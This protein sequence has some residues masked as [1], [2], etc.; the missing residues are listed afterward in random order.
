MA[1][2]EISVN[3]L[4]L[5]EVRAYVTEVN[6]QVERMRA[7][8]EAAVVIVKLLKKCGWTPENE[9]FIPETIPFVAAVEAW[10]DGGGS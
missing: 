9:W 3:L 5:P 4:D 2:A 1:K 6:A 10:Q 8:T 7:V